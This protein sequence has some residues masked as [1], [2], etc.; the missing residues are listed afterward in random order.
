MRTL[1]NEN[2]FEMWLKSTLKNYCGDRKPYIEE[3]IKQF[4]K[5]GITSYEI[6]GSKT[7]SGYPAI[8]KYNIK[9]HF[10]DEND[11]EISPE[12]NNFAYVI[13]EIIL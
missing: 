1:H 7:K 2:Y 10:F 3:L 5:S 13:L 11:N 8:Y 12:E 4:E 9:F 6:P